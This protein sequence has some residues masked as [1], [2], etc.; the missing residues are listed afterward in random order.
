[1]SKKSLIDF[2][3]SRKGVVCVD[4][5]VPR[6]A[7]HIVAHKEGIIWGEPMWAEEH[8]THG[9]HLITGDVKGDGPWAI[10]GRVFEE[11]TEDHDYELIASMSYVGQ[12][13]RDGERDYAEEC[14]ILSRAFNE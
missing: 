7:T 1:M 14:K 5:G 8:S 12:R 9:V 3:A 6:L 13:E 4:G 2:C 11:M 10:S